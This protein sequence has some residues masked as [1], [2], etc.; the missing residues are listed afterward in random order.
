MSDLI[1][2]LKSM[3]LTTVQIDHKYRETIPGVIAKMRDLVDSSDEARKKKRKPKKMKLGKDNLYPAE[4]ESIRAWWNATK[5]ESKDDESSVTPDQV[6]SHVT[7]LRTR[8][9]QLQMIIILEILALE[10][11]KA[12]DE[13]GTFDLPMLPGATA[14]QETPVAPPKKRNKHNLPVL[15]DVHADRLA[16]WQSIATDEQLLLEDTQMTSQAVDGQLQ[17][18]PS[19][20]PLKDF[21]VDVII[22]LYVLVYHPSPSSNQSQLLGALAC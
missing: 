17:Q 20:E 5:P 11:L 8:E 16:I 1:D 19:P 10:P 18:K 15:L 13:V 4:D 9:T 21:C 6:K 2:F 22:P 12:A 7:L 14:L 3:V